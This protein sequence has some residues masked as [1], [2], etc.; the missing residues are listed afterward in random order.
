MP[1]MLSV[2][3]LSDP[4]MVQALAHPIRLRIVEALREPESPAHLARELGEPRQRVHYHVKELQR[5]GLL[6]QVGERRTGNFVEN[7]YQ[8]VASAFVISPRLAWNDPRRVSAL[9]DQVSLES[10]VD[11][12]ERLQRDAAR[13]LDLAAFD[14]ARVASASVEAE[15]RFGSEAERTEFLKAYLTAVG[16]LLKKY[17]A[18][19]GGDRFRILLA[20]Y[21][22]VEDDDE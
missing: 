17:G 19:E 5:V 8:A 1:D 20:T 7:L 18:A 22:S 14:G 6:E 9:R 11:L 15:V 4:A 2:M 21:P 12:G 3:S 13:L 10:L 16:P